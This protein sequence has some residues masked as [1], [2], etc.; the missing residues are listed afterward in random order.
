MTATASSERG[1][2]ENIAKATI[3]LILAVETIF[4]GTLLTAYLF[5]RTGQAEWPFAHPSLERTIIP[6]L[7]TFLLLVSALITW[8][9]TRDI[10]KGNN[11]GLIAS[12]VLTIL[13]GMIFVVGQV[14]EFNRAGMRPDDA[15]FGGVFFALMGFHAL[16]VL[17]GLVILVL[18]FGRAQLGDFTATRHIAVTMGAWFW[19]YVVAVWVVLFSAL[20]LV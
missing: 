17:A 10:R 11:T 18:N 1:S 16:H 7:N 13:L 6:G 15:T 20:Y 9:G 5:L 8:H 19:Y 3:F 4:F 14:F 12:L 2:K